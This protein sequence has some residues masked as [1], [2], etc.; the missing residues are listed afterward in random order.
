MDLH[1]ITVFITI[2]IPF[3]LASLWAIIDAAQ[4]EFGTLQQKVVW[5]FVAAIPFF[6]FLIYLAVGIRKG[7]R[8]KG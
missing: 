5:M 6:G 4:R 7:R 3:V 8:V 2:C 1:T